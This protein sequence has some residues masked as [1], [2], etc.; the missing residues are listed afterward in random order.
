MP[1][2]LYNVGDI[3]WVDFPF[4]ENPEKSKLRPGVIIDTVPGPAE[5]ESL[6]VVLYVTT[7]KHRAKEPSFIELL[8]PPLDYVSYIGV[9][10][11]SR[12]S[13]QAII[14]KI[15]SIDAKLL[16]TVIQA[17]RQS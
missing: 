3:V 11:I 15:G 8:P 9:K 7:S 14:R 17:Y 13:D 4:E 2:K 5:N 10:K 12:F 1:N 6:W 16:E